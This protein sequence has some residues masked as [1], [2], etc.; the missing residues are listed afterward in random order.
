M[1]SVGSG[2]RLPILRLVPA[3]FLYVHI[4]GLDTVCLMGG[5]HSF[6]VRIAGLWTAF[7]AIRFS[8][9]KSKTLCFRLSSLHICVPCPNC[10]QSVCS[11]VAVVQENWW[12]FTNQD[13]RLGA[14]IFG[15]F[16]EDNCVTHLADMAASGLDFE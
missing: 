6:F 9:T 15:N 13:P 14:G 10:S 8:L 5:K 12:L 7:L 16:C 2:H 11:L 4:L 3:F 1:L